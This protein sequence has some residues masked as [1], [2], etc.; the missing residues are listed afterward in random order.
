MLLGGVEPVVTEP[1]DELAVTDIIDTDDGEDFSAF[2]LPP[3]GYV[4][5]QP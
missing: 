2:V 4:Q 3:Y 5:F 1:R